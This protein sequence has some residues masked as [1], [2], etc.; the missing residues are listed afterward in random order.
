MKKVLMTASVY[1]HI[2]NFHLPYLRAF[3]RFGWE[4]HVGCG[5]ILSDAPYIDRAIGLPF[6]KDM[7]SLLNLRT[8]RKIRKSVKAENSDL[9]ITH[10]SSLKRMFG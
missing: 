2:R 7:F 10:T 9:I 8:A 4:T 1:T 5:G 3:Q 6:K